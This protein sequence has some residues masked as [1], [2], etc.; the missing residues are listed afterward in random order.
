MMVSPPST[1]REKPYSWRAYVPAARSPSHEVSRARASYSTPRCVV[2]PSL[3]LKPLASRRI[4]WSLFMENTAVLSEK[5]AVR[6]FQPA[7][8]ESSSSLSRSASVCCR[9]RRYTSVISG[10]R[11]PVDPDLYSLECS[12]GCHDSVIRGATLWKSSL[13]SAGREYRQPPGQGTPFWSVLPL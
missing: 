5:F 6:S 8:T 4:T 7:S 2:L 13:R 10:G 1:D 12:P 11:N 9:C 3:T